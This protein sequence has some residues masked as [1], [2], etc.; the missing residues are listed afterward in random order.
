MR[1]EQRRF[2]PSNIDADLRAALSGSAAIT[3]DEDASL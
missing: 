1:S 2:W 3:T